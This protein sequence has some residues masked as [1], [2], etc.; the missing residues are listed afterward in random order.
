MALEYLALDLLLLDERIR[1]LERR[2]ERRLLRDAQNPFFLPRE[3]FINCFRLTPDLVIHV[4]NT[5]RADLQN[6]RI[7]GLAIEIKLNI[8]QTTTSHCIHAVTAAI[9][10]RLLR[11]WIKFPTTVEDRQQARQK[12]STA[13]QPFE[14]AIGAMDCTLVHIIAP[15]EHEEAFIN[16]H[17]NHALNVQAIVDPDMKILNINPRYPGARNDAYIWSVSPIR[18]VME[19]HFNRGESKTW[20]IGD[21]GYPL[22]PWLMTPLPGFPEDT[23]QYQYTKQLCKA[24]NVVERFF[25]VFKS[26]WR[27]LS[28]QR[29]LMY[30]PAFAA[31]IVNACAILHNIRIEHRLQEFQVPID[32]NH[33]EN[34][35]AGH[36]DIVDEYIAQRGP[37]AVAQRIQRQIMR[38]I[39][40]LSRCRS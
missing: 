7:T 39:S 35:N 20:L 30:K 32:V 27:C 22:E 1:R 23:R 31:Q 13:A 26:V 37:N 8:S 11:R 10:Q 2:I 4:T 9:N 14:G 25:G 3:E 16:H 34:V 24:R 36:V 21:A 33:P 38:Q 17:G 29:V 12:F 28:Y 40:K 6:R 15:H 18:Q 5:L 19:F